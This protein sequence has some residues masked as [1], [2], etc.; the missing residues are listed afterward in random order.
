[1]KRTGYI[2]IC[3]IITA[4]L[5]SCGPNSV[6]AEAVENAA[7]STAEAA[8]PAGASDEDEAAA[9]SGD[10]ELEE[11]DIPGMEDMTDRELNDYLVDQAN[12]ME[13]VADPKA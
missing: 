13:V 10:E 4:M 6:G 11:L 7:S 5:C 9:N 3:A 2:F 12:D 1:M 8:A